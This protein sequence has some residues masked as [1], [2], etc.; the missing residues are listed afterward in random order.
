MKA[1]LF[2]LDGTLWDACEAMVDP[3]NRTLQEQ[4]PHLQ[5]RVTLA[6]IRA[7]QGKNLAG[8]AATTFPELPPNE[9]E[10]VVAAACAAEVPVL[11]QTGVGC[12]RDCLRCWVSCGSAIGSA[13]S[14][15]ASVAISKHS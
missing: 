4:F 14:V 2:D 12:M 13:L 5:R 6:D 9:G 7:M 3:W 1:I 10:A 15:T 11:A 8:C